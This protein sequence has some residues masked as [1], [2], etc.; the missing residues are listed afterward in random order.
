[1]P[2]YFAYGSNMHRTRIER[3]LGPVKDLG[4]GRLDGFRHR[5]DKCGD[6]GTAKGNVSPAAGGAVHGVLY[7]LT[8]EQLQR[9]AGFER[10]YRCEV[11]VVV[12]LA[13]G[14]RIAAVAFEA[15]PEVPRWPPSQAYL[16]HYR[17]GMIEHELP[18]DYRMQ[19]LAEGR[20]A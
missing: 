10:G 15:D 4:R 20:R 9:L 18:E 3:R 12:R 16:E 1:M 14:E 19:I 11:R 13:T 17:C 2:F 7:E 5:F 6:D 8:G